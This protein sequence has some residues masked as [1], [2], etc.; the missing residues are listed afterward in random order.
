MFK[1]SYNCLLSILYN[2]VYLIQLLFAVIKRVRPS[3]YANKNNHC[4]DGSKDSTS[5]CCANDRSRRGDYNIINEGAVA[6]SM[7][8]YMYG[9]M[10]SRRIFYRQKEGK[11][12]DK[13]LR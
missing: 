4:Q 10:N 1:S 7:Q 2:K 13:G 11:E 3:T 12:K 6:K 9:N 5:Q 8:N